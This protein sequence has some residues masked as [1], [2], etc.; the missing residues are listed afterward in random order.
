MQ[1]P[2]GFDGARLTIKSFFATVH[3]T[4]IGDLLFPGIDAKGDISKHPTALS[5]AKELGEKLIKEFN[6]PNFRLND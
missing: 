3:V 6:N 2:S 4:Y 1:K 5:E